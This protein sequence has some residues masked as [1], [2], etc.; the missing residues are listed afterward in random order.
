MEPKLTKHT[1]G[2]LALFI[3]D[4]VPPSPGVMGMGPRCEAQ[5]SRSLGQTHL[6][7]CLL[8]VALL[9]VV[10]GQLWHQLGRNQ[11]A[12]AW[13]LPHPAPVAAAPCCPLPSLPSPLPTMTLSPLEQTPP[14][15]PGT[16][17][18]LVAGVSGGHVTL[19]QLPAAHPR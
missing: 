19:D 4:P 14:W 3:P 12:W 11:A 18:H 10:P 2:L 13:G 9:K 15:S 17:G 6:W 7:P 1:G 5:V 16:S 8:H